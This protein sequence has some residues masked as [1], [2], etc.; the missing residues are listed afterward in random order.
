[1]RLHF[2]IAILLMAAGTAP[3]AD[4]KP[5]EDEE[6]RLLEQVR[7]TA[8]NYTKSL[9]DFICTQVVKRYL[10]SNG[11]DRWTLADTLTVKLSYFGQKEDYKLL[12][13]DNKP[14]NLEYMKTGGAASK[15]EFG[16]C[17]SRY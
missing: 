11:R 14:T 17:N 12:L 1:M 10:D 2:S 16:F 3:A 7:E 13:I 15:G 9:P 8:L 6:A 4:Q 5:S